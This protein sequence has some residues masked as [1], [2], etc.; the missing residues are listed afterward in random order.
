M[1][2]LLSRVGLAA[3]A[4]VM[5]SFGTGCGAIRAAANPKVAWA[6]NDPAPMSVV[7]RRADVAETTAK[8][9]DRLLTQTKAEGDGFATDVVPAKE[10]A[11]KT[12]GAVKA[13]TLYA[14]SGGARVVA[15]EYWAKKL[16]EV[17]KAK[18]EPSPAPPKVAAPKAKKPVAAPAE[19][20]AKKAAPAKEPSPT[21]ALAV[22]EGQ[23][24]VTVLAALDRSLA[25]A[26]N[27]IMDG[28]KAIGEAKGRIAMLEAANDDKK[29]PAPDKKANEAKISDLE[30]KIDVLEKEGETLTKAFFPKAKAAAQAADPAVREK[31]GPALVQLRQA[32]EDANTANSAA[33]LRYPLAAKTL[34]DSAKTMALVYVGDVVEEKTGKRP[35]LTSLQPGV[36]LENGEVAL[37]LNGLS[38]A[39]LGKLSVGEVTK[40]VAGRTT[41]WVKR[42]LGLL[43]TISATKEVLEVEDDL[44]GA[45]LD[46]FAAAG[47]KAPAPTLV[48]DAPGGTPRS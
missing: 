48:P 30:K 41:A 20:A 5:M 9:V 26:W 15:A 11:E 33:A 1:S 21:V 12:L 18:A 46:G 42:A 10:E 2:A 32:V 19:K 8:E 24:T 13:H 45:L 4:A 17:G 16:P 27:E 37:T 43:G 35:V 44:V 47:W 31:L 25:G 28:R 39:D 34:L 7:V 29:T 14:S 40:E 38:P 3:F 22:S 6:L 36:S 23:A